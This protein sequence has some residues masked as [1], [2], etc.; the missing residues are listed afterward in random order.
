M[1][2]KLLEVEKIIYDRLEKIRV[3]HPY[4]ISYGEI[5]YKS[6]YIDYH[7]PV[8]ERIWFQEGDLRVYLHKIHKC[9]NESVE[10]LFHLHPWKSAVRII[11]GGY[12][13]GI[14]HSKTNETPVV[15][16]KLFLTN[17]CAYEMIEPDGWHYVKPLQNYSYSLMVTG[18]RNTRQ[19]PVEPDKKFR[20]LTVN[21]ILDILQ[22]FKSCYHDG[23]L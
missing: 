11:E 2:K 17:G 15:D 9:E 20:E 18:E 10:A 3:K 21:E 13:M 22:K 14:G 6:M 23:P 12:E 7:P 8:V 16:C 5:A 4:E 19:M 1:I